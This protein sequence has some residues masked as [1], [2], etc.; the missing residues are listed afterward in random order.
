M[1]NKLWIE[2]LRGFAEKVEITLAAPNGTVG[3]GLTL[4]TGPNNSGKS[5]IIEA[6]KVRSAFHQTPSFHAGMRNAKTEEVSISYEIDGSIDTLKSI[7]P[8]SS[9]TQAE[10]VSDLAPYVVPSRRQFQPQFGRSGPSTRNQYI[11]NS[12]NHQ[13]LREQIMSGFEGRLFEL[14][15]NSDEFDALLR[16]IVP[17]FMN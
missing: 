14:E 6:I 1:L 12:A 4:L 13:V 8:G 17:E 11:Q 9:E 7:K 3:S 15:R 2:G 5:T 16:E 10:R